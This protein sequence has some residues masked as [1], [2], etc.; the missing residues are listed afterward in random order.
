MDLKR[1]KQAY[2]QLQ[3]L[4]ERLTYKVRPR[5]GGALTRPGVDQLEEK[6]R[7][8]ATYTVE[9]KEILEEVILSA[10]T[11]PKAPPE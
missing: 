9:L 11:R 5:S 4:D 10:A 1:L 7:E 3:G 2:E 8:L 6:I